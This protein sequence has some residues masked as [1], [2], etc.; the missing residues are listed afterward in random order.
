MRRRC[1]SGLI[2]AFVLG[3]E[4]P[5]DRSLPG[6]PEAVPVYGRDEAESI[7]LRICGVLGLSLYSTREK[8]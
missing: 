4:L 8:E 2:C 5:E 6:L 1:G 3:P 7:A